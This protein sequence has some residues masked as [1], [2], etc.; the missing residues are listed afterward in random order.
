MNL[1]EIVLKD[2]LKLPTR[3][4]ED[5]KRANLSLLSAN[6]YSSLKEEGTLDAKSRE[7]LEKCKNKGE[8]NLVF[9]N[10]R[11]MEE[12]K[13]S[14][15]GLVEVEE[16]SIDENVW[17]MSSF[18]KKKNLSFFEELAFSNLQKKILLQFK[19][20]LEA[21]L[22]FI[23]IN[24]V[25]SNHFDIV[26]EI[27]VAE[28]VEASVRHSLIAAEGVEKYFNNIK[29]L[30]TLGRLSK[31]VYEEGFLN[32]EGFN[33]FE[34]R[35]RQKKASEFLVNQF[36][37]GSHYSRS[38]LY[39]ALEE[40]KAKCDLKATYALKGSRMMDYFVFI[41]QL[42]QETESSQV[43]KGILN[44]KAVLIFNGEVYVGHDALKAVSNQ[45]NHN[46]ALGDDAR[47]FSRPQLDIH[48]DD[49]KCGH[50][51]ALGRLGDQEFFYI[52]SRAI[53]KDKAKKLMAM[54]FV[55][56]V[57]RDY[58]SSFKRIIRPY[59]EEDYWK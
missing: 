36:S 42:S 35:V 17:D 20:T 10:G 51:S 24:T 15:K 41:A 6:D 39:I 32:A 43:Y 40:E 18:I 48:C 13:E 25:S 22:N 53:S 16:S 26:L 5:W 21:P 59:F 54:G 12:S 49:V 31:C 11:L 29:Q 3:H 46:L 38:S 8:Y 50:G 23:W 44:E 30:I 7:L 27:E 9:L 33:V 28:K 52:Q 57:I 58:L 45:L 34:T 55:L 14:L 2:G 56:D 19:K 37:V 4:D 47:V 1:K